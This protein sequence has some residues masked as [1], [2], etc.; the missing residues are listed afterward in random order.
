[1][2][3]K[4]AREQLRDLLP[5]SMVAT[6]PWLLDQGLSLHFLDNAIRSGTLV[7]LAPGVYT[8]HKQTVRWQGIVASLQRMSE[9]PTHVGGLTALKLA[10]LTHFLSTGPE[11][12]IQLYSESQLPRWIQRVAV[13]ADFE[14]HGTK[15]LWQE[16]IMVNS[17]F[18]RQY[19]WQEGLPPIKYSCPEKAIMEVLTGVPSA[20][21]FE[22][23]DALMQGLLNLSPRK[24][25][26]LLR[27]CRSVKV[28]RL[29]LWLA[30]RQDHVWFR[31]LEPG[32]Y[33]LGS[34]KRVIAEK[35]RLNTKWAI[36]V[37]AEMH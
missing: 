31:C 14:W 19:H 8:L 3:N 26:A 23:A 18:S 20:I 36:T 13:T 33:D 22:H 10:N 9:N 12:R 34:G 32:E 7:P 24:T 11:E 4:K 15:K 28:K 6:K 37:P 30:E 21:S 29:F 16:S 5:L 17:G 35:G 25:D 1:M 2:L 27:G